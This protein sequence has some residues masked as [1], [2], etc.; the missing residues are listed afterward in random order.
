MR[1]NE[2]IVREHPFLALE[3]EICCRP[4]TVLFVFKVQNFGRKDFKMEKYFILF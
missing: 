3:E 1:D 2:E 4:S